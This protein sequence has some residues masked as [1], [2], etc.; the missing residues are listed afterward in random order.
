[1]E[2]VLIPILD[3]ASLSEARAQVRALDVDAALVDRALLIVSELGRN[4]LRHAR[5][6]SI[7]SRAVDGGIEVVATDSGPGIGDFAGSLDAAPRETGSLG[8]GFGSVRRLASSLDVDVRLGEGTLVRARVH[9]P[10]APRRREVGIYGRAIAGERRSGDHAAFFRDRDLL[11]LAVCDGLGHGEPARIAADAAVASFRAGASREP[12]A[13]IEDCHAALGATRGAVMAVARID[14]TT[15]AMTLASAGNVDVQATAFR[16]L[17]RFGGS[18]AV[19]GGRPGPLKVRTETV[20]L[21]ADDVVI[22]TT[23]GITSKAIIE[24]DPLLL[25]AHPAAIA[26]RILE[27]FARPNDDA[28]VLVA[29]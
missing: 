7:E 11:M 9:V 6:G 4:Q 25:R 12:A 18:S 29:R 26:Q 23:D 21:L 14:E 13:V 5:D 28:L 19:V 8:V 22:V 20:P 24:D 2:T 15:G 16:R 17:R 1:M 27:R 10:D 3:E